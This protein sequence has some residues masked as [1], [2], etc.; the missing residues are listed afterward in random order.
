VLHVVI[1][2]AS[3]GLGAALARHYGRQGNR[4]T[5]LARNAERLV[6][7]TVA[8]QAQSHNLQ[9]YGVPCDVTDAAAMQHVL[10]Q[11]D[12]LVPVDLVIA[13]AGLG[14]SA[15]L[16]SP[17]GEDASMARTVFA[18][19]TIGVINTLAP[20]IDRFVARRRGHLVII[21]SMAAFQGVAESPSYAA[22]KAAVRIYGQGL[23]R[24]LAPHNVQVTVVCPG[25]IDTPMSASL[26]FSPPFVWSADAAVARIVKG[27]ARGEAEIVFPWQ[28]R[29]FG[30]VLALLPERLA[31]RMLSHGR[32]WMER[33]RR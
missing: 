17:T 20:L 9:I 24:L 8:C 32:S 13:N 12:D 10:Q 23:R 25:F 31:D 19:N 3:S 27:L 14:G 22:S 16:S 5:L 30:A 11:A 26:P 28:L 18:V 1:T 21:S 4:L 7:L 6:A 15:V 33:A 2:G 29:W